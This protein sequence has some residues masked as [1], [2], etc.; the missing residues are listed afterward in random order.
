MRILHTADVHLGA[1]FLSLGDK[2]Q[3][4]RRQLLRTFEQVASLA[5]AQH[6]DLFIIAGDLFDS[7]N[8]PPF[9]VQEA[10]RIL[11]K[12]GDAG[13]TTCLIPGTHD[14]IEPRSVYNAYDF[15]GHCPA[16]RI[17]AG[18][19]S[20]L[21]LPEL[22]AVVYGLLPPD[23]AGV[24][25]L[26][27]LRLEEAA[28]Q[29]G[30]AHCSF[31]IPDRVEGDSLMVT[32]E[33]VAASGLNYLALGHWHSFSEFT[34][35]S[36]KACYSGAPEVID[37]DQAGA[38]KVVLVNIERSGDVSIQPVQVGS[39]RFERL[40]IPLDTAISPAAVRESIA[41]LADRSLILEV[42]LEGLQA[43]D[44]QLDVEEME[45]ALE[46]E[47]FALRIVDHSHAALSEVDINSFAPE[48]VVGR[49]V[50]L[51]QQRIA[52][53]SAGEASEY[54]EALRLGVALLQ[55]REVLR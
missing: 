55:G 32:R 15:A 46:D 53:A 19:S 52:S 11:R 13:I 14:P 48:T 22:D 12:V 54:E 33:E 28:L 50:R 7:N 25:P 43:L 17:L 47:F 2:G 8:P 51:M 45:R 38:G 26:R 21:R 27:S 6:S 44:F 36:T 16:L 24:S 42:S 1:K 5:I 39:R 35:G 40:R 9:Y 37:L 23:G 49:Y 3:E 29:I 20:T 18:E 30:I 10:I 4:H 31:H 34:C 41:A